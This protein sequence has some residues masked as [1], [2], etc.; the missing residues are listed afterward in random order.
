MALVEAGYDDDDMLF[1][2]EAQEEEYL[3]DCEAALHEDGPC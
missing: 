1:D 2:P 3:K